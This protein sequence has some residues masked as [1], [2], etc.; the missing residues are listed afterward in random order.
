[1]QKISF[2]ETL[3]NSLY[4]FVIFL[5]INVHFKFFPIFQNKKKKL[6]IKDASMNMNM[7]TR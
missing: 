7:M 3:I 2:F 5:F 6:N 4:V 1:M